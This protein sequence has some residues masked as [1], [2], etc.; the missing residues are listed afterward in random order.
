[1][2]K[3]L[4]EKIQHYLNLSF[5]RKSQPKSTIFEIT[6]KCIDT[7]LNPSNPNLRF[8]CRL[9]LHY[10]DSK[11]KKLKNTLSYGITWDEYL[12]LNKSDQ[13]EMDIH[14]GSVEWLKFKPEMHPDI[15]AFKQK[16]QA[17]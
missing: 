7:Y 17:A 9:Q 5:L 15:I 1:M 2:K 4:G 3:T 16:Q 6:A 13:W 10:I 8:E 11:T 12:L 14:S